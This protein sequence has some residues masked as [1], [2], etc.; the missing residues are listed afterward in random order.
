MFPVVPG[1]SIN[2]WDSRFTFN[3][4]KINTF[5]CTTQHVHG[6]GDV[7]GMRRYMCIYINNVISNVGFPA[8]LVIRLKFLFT[9]IHTFWAMYILG[10]RSSWGTS[11]VRP[12][13]SP[14]EHLLTPALSPFRG[15][16]IRS[17]ACP[18]EV[19]YSPNDSCSHFTQRLFPPNVP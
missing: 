4:W 2:S 6:K 15:A 13:W 1:S 10:L 18:E 12:S 16:R 19:V 17:H 9:I 14:S 8:M 7:A 5:Y 11:Q 3:L